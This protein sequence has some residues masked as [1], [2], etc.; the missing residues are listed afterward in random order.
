[1]K[2]RLLLALAT[3]GLIVSSTIGISAA[4]ASADIFDNRAGFACALRE[5]F[6]P[7]WGD[8]VLNHAHP[9]TMTSFRV[10]YRCIGTALVNPCR[11]DVDFYSDGTITGPWQ[12]IG[13]CN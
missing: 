6:P 1:M 7:G 9:L 3:V 11:W 5:P 4:P 2:V 13:T 8:W 10:T 12:M